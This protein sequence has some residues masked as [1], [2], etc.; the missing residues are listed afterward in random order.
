[1]KSGWTVN[2]DGTAKDALCQDWGYWESKDEEDILDREIEKKFRAG[3]LNSNILFENSQTVVLIQG[4]EQGLYCPTF[5]L[6][7]IQHI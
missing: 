2:P 7:D 5:D 1:M 4:G 3:Y 6:A